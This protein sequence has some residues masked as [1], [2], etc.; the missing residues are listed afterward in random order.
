MTA[1]LHRKS[2]NIIASTERIMRVV[3]LALSLGNVNLID[4]LDGRFG[5]IEC[6]IADYKLTGQLPT[7]E[8]P[9]R[10]HGRT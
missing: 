5:D 4:H 3:E 1:T 10:T 7:D 9:R 6:E 2:E 8:L